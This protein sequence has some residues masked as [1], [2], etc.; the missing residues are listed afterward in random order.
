MRLNSSE[1]GRLARELMEATPALLRR[2]EC[3]YDEILIDEVQDLSGYDW[4]IIHELLQ[5][6]ID[7]RMV[8]D[9]RQAV[10]STNPRGQKNKQY[11]YAGALEWFLEREK[12]G[13][14]SISYANTTYRCRT[15]IVMFS[16]TIFDASW[17]F[18]DTTS[19]N[20]VVSEHDGVFLV[21]S[22]HIEQYVERYRPQC[23]R[24]TLV[25]GKEFALDF[26]NFKVSKGATFERVLI[27]PTAPIKAFIQKQ[28]CLEST[29]AAA[30]YVAATRAK[31][32]LAIVID[33]PV[34]SK[35]P[36]WVP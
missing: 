15:E 6:L 2:L 36:V 25:S 33:K 35:L 4:E 13:L 32:S 3:L 24:S 16:D 17:G 19:A 18:P 34:N 22:Q 21:H 30:L 11:G 27:V 28:T 5:S 12:G 14:L 9:V 10:V 1:L 23:L 29:S 26:M 7:V 31:Q 8:G 20:H